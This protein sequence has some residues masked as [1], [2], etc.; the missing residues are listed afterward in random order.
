MNKK[1]EAGLMII[2]LMT[3]T[4]MFVSLMF[5]AVIIQFLNNLFAVVLQIVRLSGYLGIVAC[6]GLLV[7]GGAF[8]VMVLLQQIEDYRGKQLENLARQIQI[9]N[10]QQVIQT[11]KQGETLFTNVKLIEYV[12][13]IQQ[14]KPNHNLWVSGDVVEGQTIVKP[15][16]KQ[17]ITPPVPPLL[18]QVKN[19]T[20]PFIFNIDGTLRTPNLNLNGETDSGKSTLAEHFIELIKRPYPQ[21]HIVLIDPKHIPSKP[22]WSLEPTI[23]TIDEVMR[24]IEY[25]HSLVQQRLDDSR[26]NPDTAEP[27]FLIIDEHDW[28]YE[29]Y[30]K[31]Y[32]GK[33]RRIFKV[34][35]ALRVH[36]VLCGQSPLSRDT[37]LSSSDYQNMGRIILASE[38]VKYL[39]SGQF[40]YQDEK[41]PLYKLAKRYKE[42]EQRFALLLPMK[43][44]PTVEQV[45]HLNQPTLINTCEPK[46]IFELPIA[47]QPVNEFD[48]HLEILRQATD[49]LDFR[50][51]KPTQASIARVLEWQNAGSYHRKIKRLIEMWET[52]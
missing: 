2:V 47:T 28:I 30:G 33:L 6:V 45:P 5:Q 46:S 16:E 13:S 7:F 22:N 3:M 52:S 12:P 4:T 1:L 43:G 32:I 15:S 48:Q 23:A 9:S 39:K 14:L 31:N 21:A 51:G 50:K 20:E 19:W 27:I 8:G 44:L 38:A 35:R 10:S 40:P 34:G 17:V 37:G 24:G 11:V 29:V 41:E 42:I 36:V 25:T 26:F 18:T 49:K